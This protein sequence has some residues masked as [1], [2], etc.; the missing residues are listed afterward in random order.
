M[1]NYSEAVEQVN[2]GKLRAL[3]TAGKA[4]LAT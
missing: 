2:A 1:S 4:R 3:A